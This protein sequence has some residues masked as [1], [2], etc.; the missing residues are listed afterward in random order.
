MYVCMYVY[1]YVYIRHTCIHTQTYTCACSVLAV[2]LE[3]IQS[4][5]FYKIFS[6]LMAKARAKVGTKRCARLWRL[7]SSDA[8]DCGGLLSVSRMNMRMRAHVCMRAHACMHAY[9]RA[10][11]ARSQTPYMHDRQAR[12]SRNRHDC[13]A[14][15][16]GHALT[17][18]AR[19]HMRAPCR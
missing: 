5:V 3:E 12:M 1:I 4:R 17:T 9:A 2:A 8:R 6:N 19:I 7:L 13:C 11:V 14:G 18:H 16:C 10:R 15:W